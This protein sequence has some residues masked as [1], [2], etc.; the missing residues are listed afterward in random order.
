MA[1]N[2]NIADLSDPNRQ[3]KI[4]EKYSE[5]YD[6]EWTDAYEALVEAGHSEETA[7]ETLRLTL[8][9]ISD[10]R[11]QCNNVIYSSFR[12]KLLCHLI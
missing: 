4:G 2:P 7:I 8:M 5:L 1:N 11:W 3:T 6:N 12:T 9:V 10:R